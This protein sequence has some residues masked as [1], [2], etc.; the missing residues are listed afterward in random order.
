M[1]HH[2]IT[3]PSSLGGSKADRKASVQ[4][5]S[6][7]SWIATDDML[8]VTGLKPLELL[9][10]MPEFHFVVKLTRLDKNWP[11]MQALY[12][13]SPDIFET[14]T[15]KGGD[16]ARLVL[17]LLKTNRRPSD[18]AAAVDTS[19]V[20]YLIQAHHI[21]N[22][23]GEEKEEPFTP[24]CASCGAH[25]PRLRCS[26]CKEMA[27]LS[28]LYCTK[29]CQLAHWKAHHKKVCC[30]TRLSKTDADALQKLMQ[31]EAVGVKAKVALL[32]GVM[33]VCSKVE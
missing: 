18:A 23:K 33:E 15:E 30:K 16:F 24:V 2:N 4:T 8:R 11:V 7:T 1:Q 31:P 13:S 32:Q 17:H 19:L 21:A 6:Q 25:D 10:S 28:V 5:D 9:N 14:A 3:F 27:C 22:A 20:E 26:A 12:E 29:A